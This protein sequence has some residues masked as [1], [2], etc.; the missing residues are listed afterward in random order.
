VCVCVCVC[1]QVKRW[2]KGKFVNRVENGGGG[3]YE[4][5]FRMVS[6][7]RLGVT[8]CSSLR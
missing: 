4:V 3:C 7:I 6:K 5:M 1:V 2:R 8:V